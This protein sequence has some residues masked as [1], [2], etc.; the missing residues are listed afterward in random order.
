MRISPRLFCTSSTTTSILLRRT[1]AATK[2]KSKVLKHGNLPTNNADSGAK[3]VMLDRK[4][5]MFD[6]KLDGVEG[7]LL[8]LKRGSSGMAFFRITLYVD[9]SFGANFANILIPQDAYLMISE[10]DQLIIASQMNRFKAPIYID[11]IDVPEY[12]PGGRQF[13]GENYRYRLDMCWWH[14]KCKFCMRTV[15]TEK[16]HN[17]K[18]LIMPSQSLPW[19]RNTMA[20]MLEEHDGTRSLGPLPKMPAWML[21]DVEAKQTR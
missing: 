3:S 6:R 4:Y 1:S 14:R 5:L 11:D 10:M 9:A 8:L 16:K 12:L 15:Q 18:Q 19:L 2:V 7:L 21:R 13:N 20:L 17:G